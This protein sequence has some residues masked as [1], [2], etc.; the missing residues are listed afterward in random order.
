MEN[1]IQTEFGKVFDFSAPFINLSSR[2]YPAQNTSIDKLKPL[3][4]VLFHDSSPNA[5]RAWTSTLGIAPPLYYIHDQLHDHWCY[6]SLENRQPS[7]RLPSEL[8]HFS[9]VF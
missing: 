6:G 3:L 9:Q 2:S 1:F 5:G 7:S 8:H 4:N